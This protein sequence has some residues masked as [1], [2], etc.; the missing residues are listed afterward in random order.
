[1]MLNNPMFDWLT[2]T[3]FEERNADEMRY[4]YCPGEYSIEKR[5]QY[6]GRGADGFFIGHA[7]QGGKKHFMM[8]ASG[9]KSDWIA[10]KYNE[11]FG[12]Y[13]WNV[14]RCDLQVTIPIPPRFSSRDLYDDLQIWDGSGKPRISQLL[15]SGDGNDTVYV[16]SRSSD[17][18]TRI[19]VKPIDGGLKALRFEVEYKGEHAHRVFQDCIAEPGNRR[20]ILGHEVRSLPML[21]N[22]LK[23]AFLRVLGATA[24]KPKINR[25]TSQSATLDWLKTQVDATVLRSIHDHEIGLEVKRLVRGW[26]STIVDLEDTV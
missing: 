20:Y 14:T 12:P 13:D 3:T 5:L 2:L 15:Q 11:H 16:G 7:M 23:T 1:M 6:Q 18:F 25:V 21:S 4:S 8:Q 26:Y 10:L 17:R 22:S 19:Y 9:E 24:H